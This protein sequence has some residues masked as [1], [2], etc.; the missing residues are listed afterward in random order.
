MTAP[1][2][3]DMPFTLSDVRLRH[4]GI[5]RGAMVVTPKRAMVIDKERLDRLRRPSGLSQV[6]R[7][8][9]AQ[10]KQRGNNGHVVLFRALNDAGE[11]VW[12]FDPE[13]SESQLADGGYV[14]TQ[15]LLPLHRRLMA[16]G[17]V[18][19]VHTEWGLRE[20]Y[21]MRHGAARLQRELASA[22][23]PTPERDVDRW[24]L[25][26]MLLH[27]ALRMRHVVDSLLPSHLAMIERRADQV[28]SLVAGLP[29]AAID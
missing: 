29:A 24:I 26:N 25:S 7:W 18:L 11:R 20:C 27:V 13:L 6:E 12:Q 14:M 2:N 16:V 1:R 8:L 15:A 19:M 3:D 17:V 28:R 10:A 4:R 9:I 22:R 21:A 23:K 5:E